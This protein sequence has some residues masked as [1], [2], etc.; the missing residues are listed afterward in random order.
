MILKSNL[1]PKLGFILKSNLVLKLDFL[2]KFEY[3]QNFELILDTLEHLK[4]RI[5]SLK[6][7]GRLPAC[8][9]EK[10]SNDN[11]LSLNCLRCQSIRMHSCMLSSC[12]QCWVWGDKSKDNSQVFQLI[13]MSL[14]VQTYEGLIHLMQNYALLCTISL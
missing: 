12:K 10:S 11:P 9:L 5:S 3:I 7:P 14:S 13:S 8:Y 4:L 2:L 6:H 1:I